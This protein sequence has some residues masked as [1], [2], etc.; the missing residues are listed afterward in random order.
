[1][2]ANRVSRRPAGHWLRPL[3][4]AIWLPVVLVALWWWG[5]E[6]LR[7]PFFPPLGA[8]LERFAAEWLG[9][10]FL[11]H[12]VP[13]LT[14]LLTGLVIAIVLGIAL[15]VLLG[16]R[17]DV[18]ETVSPVLHFARSLPAIALL[19]VMMVLFGT[20]PFSKT[21]LIFWGAFW[22]VLLN[23]IDG[24]RLIPQQ[25]SQMTAVYR[26]TPANRLFRVTVP[27]AFPQISIGITLSISIALV[28]MIASE[29]YGSTQGIGYVVLTAQQSFRTVDV[30]AGVLLLGI[31]GYLFSKGYSLIEARLLRWRAVR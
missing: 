31:L 12:A 11:E 30:W 3:L 1:M 24:V 27:G 9:P 14:N 19:P 21:A 7:S 10:G 22:P 23:T 2:N 13:S 29:I 25:I 26:V 6:A 8:I 20:G 15:G 16:L 28:L 18:E 4:A 5:S 17:K